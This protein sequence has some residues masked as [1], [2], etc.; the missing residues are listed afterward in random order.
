M[1]EAQLLDARTD[2]GKGRQVTR[3]VAVEADRID[4]PILAAALILQVKEMPAGFGPGVKADAT[5]L[6]VADDAGPVSGFDR[7]HPQVEN[8]VFWRQPR[9]CAAVRR[10]LALRSRRIAEQLRAWDER[11]RG[12]RRGRHGR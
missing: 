8:P 4:V 2:P 1:I 12:W 3:R 7:C 9:Q 6:V 5:L 10:D 11:C